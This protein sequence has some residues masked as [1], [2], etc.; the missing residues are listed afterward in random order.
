M[1]PTDLSSESD[2]SGTLGLLFLLVTLSG[3]VKK[4]SFHLNPS[5]HTPASPEPSG[6]LRTR[7]TRCFQSLR[8]ILDADR[9]AGRADR[10]QERPLHPGEAHRALPAVELEGWGGWGPRLLQAQRGVPWKGRGHQSPEGMSIS[11]LLIQCKQRQ[12]KSLSTASNTLQIDC[13]SQTGG[14]HKPEHK[15]PTLLSVVM[16]HEAG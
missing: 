15:R 9:R 2:C 14:P 1:R 6:N 3:L 12:V 8:D 11:A 13:K 16:P 5:P 4:G 7:R 10:G